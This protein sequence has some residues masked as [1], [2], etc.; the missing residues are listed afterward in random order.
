MV[1]YAEAILN[2]ISRNSE[3]YA[4]QYIFQEF[5]SYAAWLIW[6]GFGK[7]GRVA[8]L[9]DSEPKKHMLKLCIMSSTFQRFH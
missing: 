8:Q 2:K 6:A 5:G 9:V 7:I 1:Q 4:S 3:K